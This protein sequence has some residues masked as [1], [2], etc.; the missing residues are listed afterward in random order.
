MLLDAQLVPWRSETKDGDE[1]SSFAVIY[2]GRELTRCQTVGRGE[3]AECRVTWPV[4][5]EVAS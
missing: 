3:S 5:P 2:E 4:V 1:I